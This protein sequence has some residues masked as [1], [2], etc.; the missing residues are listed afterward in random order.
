M[1]PD[2]C[3]GVAGVCHVYADCCAVYGGMTF[4]G[5]VLYLH[6][7]HRSHFGSVQQYMYV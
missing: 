7:Y 2:Y 4:P 1:H 3:G 6:W 5:C